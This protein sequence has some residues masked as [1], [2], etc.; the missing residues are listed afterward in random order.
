MSLGSGDCGAYT[1]GCLFTSNLWVRWG[2]DD[3]SI[4]NGFAAYHQDCCH[5]DERVA[6]SFDNIRGRGECHSCM[7]PWKLSPPPWV[8]DISWAISLLGQIAKEMLPIQGEGNIARVF[9]VTSPSLFPATY[10]HHP[11]QSL[12]S[13]FHTDPAPPLSTVRTLLLLPPPTHEH[14]LRPALVHP[15][16]G[17]VPAHPLCIQGLCS[18]AVRQERCEWDSLSSRGR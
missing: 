1:G 15:L 11:C 7:Q 2:N 4:G 5:I 8:G 17:G 6:G 12:C 9:P 16:P 10:C 14:L 3:R 13:L 18:R